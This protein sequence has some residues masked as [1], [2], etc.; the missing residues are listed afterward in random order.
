MPLA[1]PRII[2][3]VHSLAP[4]RRTDKLP[5]GILKVIGSASIDLSSDQELLFAGSNK[6]PWAAE[7]KTVST[8]FTAKV[9]AYPDFLFSLFL[10]ATVTVNA[11]ESGGA[12]SS[13]LT[14]FLGATIQSG[15]NGVSAV[16]IIPSTGA[17]NLK[18]GKYM[19]RATA[20]TT[21]KVYLLSD[22]DQR[23]T[24]APYVDDTLE[25]ATA[26]I[27]VGTTDVVSLGL[28][29]TGVGTIAFTIGNTAIFEVRPP[30]TQS[31]NMIIGQAGV[32]FPNFGCILLAQKRATGEMFEIDAPNCVGSGLPISFEEQ[33]FSQPELKMTMLYDS[34]A[35]QVMSIRHIVP[36]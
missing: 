12:I 22:I 11:A 13:P 2:Y 25:V 24:A 32:T 19:V 9:K 6:F 16:S 31:T 33:A 35:D 5:F 8:E 27:I 28:R 21:L 10:G 20:A 17:A 4:Y 23:G 3:G 29:F 36:A 26:S 34:S 14:N 18:F 30:N 1:N 15:T 7:G